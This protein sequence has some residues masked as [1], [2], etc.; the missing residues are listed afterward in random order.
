MEK[1]GMSQF[2]KTDNPH[3]LYRDKQNRMLAFVLAWRITLTSIERVCE[4]P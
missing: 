4:S 3:R 1:P 2:Y